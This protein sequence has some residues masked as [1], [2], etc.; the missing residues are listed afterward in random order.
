VLVTVMAH[1][2][3]PLMPS[4]AASAARTILFMFNTFDK[5]QRWRD[6]LGADRFE[7]GFPNMI[8]FLQDDKLRSVVTGPG[9]V[10][11]LTSARW[12]ALFKQA[13]LPTELENDID[14]FLRSHVAFVV[15]LMVA[16]QWTWQRSTSLS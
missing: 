11:T 15:P 16:A 10:T 14:S 9:M 6:A 8:A 2:V 12:A 7:F 5:T 1:Q 4:L 3:D 13:G